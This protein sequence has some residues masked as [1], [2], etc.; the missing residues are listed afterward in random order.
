M[1]CW[2]SLF[3]ARTYLRRACRMRWGWKDTKM[4][5]DAN[6]AFKCFS[7]RQIN[8]KWKTTLA[9]LLYLRITCYQISCYI[10]GH[11]IAPHM[12]FFQAAH[13][14]CQRSFFFL[15]VRFLVFG[16]EPSSGGKRLKKRQLVAE[17]Q[18]AF[19]GWMIKRVLDKR[20]KNM[21][22]D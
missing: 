3:S 17:S 14:A 10:L 8:D 9:Y 22:R 6:R 20:E 18:A 12:M 11:T 5:G 15:N 19:F 2:R 1:V 13:I 4:R 7:V 16:N 21:R